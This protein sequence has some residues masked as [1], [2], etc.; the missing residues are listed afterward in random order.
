MLQRVLTLGVAALVWAVPAVA[1]QRGTVEFG[2]FGSAARP[3]RS[4]LCSKTW[5]KA[6]TS[7]RPSNVTFISPI[8]TF[9]QTFRWPGGSGSDDTCMDHPF[10]V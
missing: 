8:Q 1:Q 4:L 2:G 9:I 6:K 5:L 3:S 10:S 7:L